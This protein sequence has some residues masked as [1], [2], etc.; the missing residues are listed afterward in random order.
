MRIALALIAMLALA[1][2]GVAAQEADD[3][4]EADRYIVRSVDDGVLRIDRQTGATS[5]CREDADGWACRA[6]ADDREALED[7]I[8]RLAEE[9]QT[10]R[11]RIDE[12]EDRQADADVAAP[13]ATERRD[14]D[15]DLPTDSEID[16][17]MDT[18]ERMMRRFLGIVRSLKD[19]FEEEPL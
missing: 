17:V 2:T 14:R 19:D 13:D 7:E 9:N 10:L 12:L 18:F 1:D 5:V 4:V 15:L 11:Q 16:Q 6:V 8:A 3:E